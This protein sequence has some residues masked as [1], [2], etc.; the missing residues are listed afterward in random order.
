MIASS[1]ASVF[2]W[3][4]EVVKWAAKRRHNSVQESIDP[5]GQLPYSRYDRQDQLS[6]HRCP[7]WEVFPVR[8]AVADAL[9]FGTK[10]P[11]GPLPRQES[12]GDDVEEV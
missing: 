9:F 3:R 6:R 11:G 1:A 4:L 10:V 2:G 12:D 5:V 8:Q 7:L